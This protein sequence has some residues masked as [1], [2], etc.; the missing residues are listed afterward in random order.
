MLMRQHQELFEAIIAGRAEEA[1]TISNRHIHYVQEVLSEVQQEARR[2]A[3]SR[4]R[5][6]VQEG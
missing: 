5:Q 3:R 4:R 6:S 1:R 2:E